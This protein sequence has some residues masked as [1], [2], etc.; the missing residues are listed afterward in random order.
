MLEV[1]D[2]SVYCPIVPRPTAVEVSTLETMEETAEEVADEVDVVEETVEI[3]VELLEGTGADTID[4][5]DTITWAED[6]GGADWTD[7][8][9]GGGGGTGAEE[10]GGGSALA[11]TL[12]SVWCVPHP[13][14]S[15][16]PRRSRN[17]QH[18]PGSD[19]SPRHGAT[20]KLPITATWSTSNHT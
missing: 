7:E 2:V 4:A 8:L 20:H 3:I 5:D 9:I 1:G 10:A 15:S 12:A 6:D 13:L 11:F 19:N 16:T 17:V 14:I 18:D